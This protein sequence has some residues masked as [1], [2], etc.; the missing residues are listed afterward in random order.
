MIR[1]LFLYIVAIHYF[2]QFQLLLIKRNTYSNDYTSKGKTIF[3]I[4]GPVS[5]TSLDS[6]AEKAHR[7]KNLVDDEILADDEIKHCIPLR[8]I[9]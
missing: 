8:A 9:D 1:F 7:I 2:I 6:S 4:S 3:F 5:S